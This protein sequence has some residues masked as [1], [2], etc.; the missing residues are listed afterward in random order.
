[1]TQS[2]L[3]EGFGHGITAWLSGAHHIVV[4]TVA[5]DADIETRC[6]AAAGTLVN[7][8][9]AA[10][11]WFALRKAERFSVTTRYFLVL[12]F[13]GSLFTGTG[14]FFFSGVA[15]FGDWEQVIRGLHPYWLFRLGLVVLGVGSYFASVLLVAR[16]LRPFASIRARITRLTWTP[17][18][19]EGALAAV[20]GLLNPAGPI[21]VL[22]SALPATLGANSGLLWIRY[23]IPAPR[24]GEHLQAIPRSYSWMAAAA[25]CGIIFIFIIGRGVTWHR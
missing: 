25:V 2:I 6:I 19:T 9:V 3:H 4:S 20:A 15:G 23:Y 12:L 24:E 7:L 18:F 21:Y 14:Y 11:L 8:L 16:E 22:L 10:L 1:M 5:M 17:Y 13:A